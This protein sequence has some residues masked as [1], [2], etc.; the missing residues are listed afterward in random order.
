[1]RT[2]DR[3]SV[4]GGGRGRGPGLAGREGRRRPQPLGLAPPAARD[5]EPDREAVPGE[6]AG[7]RDRGHAPRRWGNRSAAATRCRSSGAAGDVGGKGSSTAKGQIAVVGA[8]MR[9]HRAENSRTR[10]QSAV[11]SRSQR[12]CHRRGRGGSS[13]RGAPPS[14]GECG[15]DLES[16]R[17][18]HDRQRLPGET[19]LK[20]SVNV[21][22]DV[23]TYWAE[24]R[25]LVTTYLTKPYVGLAP[26]PIQRAKYPA[27]GRRV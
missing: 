1:M 16:R 13:R 22:P 3:V 24:R 18:E 27:S 10:C 23:P 5:L 11:R 20:L 6:S 15:R 17:V 12:P 4:G 26:P 25:S 19:M 9:S 21:P 2:T 7:H 14:G 8:M